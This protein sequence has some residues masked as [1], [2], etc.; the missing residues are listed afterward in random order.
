MPGQG[1]GSAAWVRPV[2]TGEMFDYDN[3][4]VW[5]NRDIARLQHY[6]L[7]PCSPFN[8]LHLGMAL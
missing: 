3:R 6:T 7:S 1:C 4:E 2:A 8:S 5:I